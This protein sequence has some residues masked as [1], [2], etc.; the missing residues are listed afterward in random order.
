M[1]ERYMTLQIGGN[2]RD[3]P[4]QLIFCGVWARELG[5]NEIYIY[6]FES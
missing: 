3:M 5:R 2:T 1:G 4:I 6:Q